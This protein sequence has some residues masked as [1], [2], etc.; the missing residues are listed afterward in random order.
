M[1]VDK[2]CN[3][4]VTSLFHSLVPRLSPCTTEKLPMMESWAGPGN[5]ATYFLHVAFTEA[6]IIPVLS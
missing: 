4:D 2:L 6:C 1:E 5:E 3:D